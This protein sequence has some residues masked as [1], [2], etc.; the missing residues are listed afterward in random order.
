MELICSYNVQVLVFHPI[1]R[2]MKHYD[3]FF[4]PSLYIFDM[5]VFWT[6]SLNQHLE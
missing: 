5:F 6:P 3:A 1:M 4:P 2:H